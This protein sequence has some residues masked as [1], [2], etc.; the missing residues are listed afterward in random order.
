MET[1]TPLHQSRTEPQPDPLWSHQKTALAF[2]RRRGERTARDGHGNGQDARGDP[3]D[4]RAAIGQ[5]RP[6]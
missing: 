2:V 3:P 4:D 6:P 1:E 5:A